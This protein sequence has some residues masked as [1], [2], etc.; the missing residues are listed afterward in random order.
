MSFSDYTPADF[1][2]SPLMFYYEVTQACDLVCKHCRASAQEPFRGWEGSFDRTMRM[3]TDAR[4][5]GL[6][7]QIN[8][9][10]TRRNFDQIDDL[11]ALLSTKGIVM[12]SVFFLIPC[13]S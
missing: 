1:A 10:I 2:I 7:V 5:I 9:T 3:M 4:Q 6:G 11:A 12:W 8:T 13:A